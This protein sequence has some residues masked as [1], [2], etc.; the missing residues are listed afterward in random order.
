MG[1][2]NLTVNKSVVNGNEDAKLT[3]TYYGQAGKEVT[4]MQKGFYG[5][6]AV[7][8]GITDNN[9][10]VVFL[11]KASEQG[12]FSFYALHSIIPG[13]SECGFWCDKSNTVAVSVIDAPCNEWDIG[14]RLTPTFPT[15][16][17]LAAVGIVLLAGAVRFVTKNPTSPITIARTA[18][19]AYKELRA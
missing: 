8:R 7:A 13:I 3:A 2:I 18:R 11:W 15:K 17:V 6:V 19:Q 14:C 4:L 5:D 1:T 16:L 12:S 10:V 9:G